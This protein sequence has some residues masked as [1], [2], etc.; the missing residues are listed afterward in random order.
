MAIISI[1]V[2]EL[3]NENMWFIFDIIWDSSFF[4]LTFELDEDE[5]DDLEEGS[6]NSV[7]FNWDIALRPDTLVDE[8]FDGNVFVAGDVLN[9]IGLKLAEKKENKW[10]INSEY[11]LVNELFEL[12]DVWT[13]FCK[14]TAL[15]DAFNVLLALGAWKIVFDNELELIEATVVILLINMFVFVRNSCKLNFFSFILMPLLMSERILIKL[16]LP[17]L[18]LFKDVL[19]DESL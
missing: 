1:R 11:E 19:L 5:E 9:E 16:W 13:K 12:V 4:L 2:F 10:L 8:L 17:W 6:T 14:L 7:I 3:N 18:M 15:L